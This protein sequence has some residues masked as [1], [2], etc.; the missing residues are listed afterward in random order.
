MPRSLEEWSIAFL[1]GAATLMI[2]VADGH[3]YAMLVLLV[4]VTYWPS[5]SIWLPKALGIDAATRQPA[6]S[7][8]VSGRN[9]TFRSPIK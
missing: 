2:F 9:K 7:F 4:I 5:V 1:M 6:V 8:E 3:R